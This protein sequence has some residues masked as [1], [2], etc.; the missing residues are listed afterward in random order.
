MFISSVFLCLFR[1]IMPCWVQV[2]RDGM[3][4]FYLLAEHQSMERLWQAFFPHLSVVRHFHGF[5]WYSIL[6]YGTRTVGFHVS[7]R[8]WFSLGIGPGL[9]FP[10]LVVALFFGF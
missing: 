10:E 3:V 6:D 5:A 9:G 2:P 4:S 1:V 8:G 7:F